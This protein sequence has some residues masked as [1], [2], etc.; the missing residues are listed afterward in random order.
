MS[1]L[2]D[3]LALIAHDDALRMRMQEKA[4]DEAATSAARACSEGKTLSSAPALASA[5]GGFAT[6]RRE[7]DPT[8]TRDTK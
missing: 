3:G 1:A 7:I 8:D 5:K 2:S 4:R 6:R